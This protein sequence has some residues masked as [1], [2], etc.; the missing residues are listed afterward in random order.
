MMSNNNNNVLYIGVTNNLERRAWE[1]KNDVDDKS[2]TSKYNCKKL[3]YYEVTTDIK[4]AILREK[5][6][7][8]WE[9]EWKNNLINKSNYKWKDLSKEIGIDDDYTNAV[10]EHYKEIAGQ[11]RNDANDTTIGKVENRNKPYPN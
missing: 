11:A 1:H 2:F 7:K 10:K 3:V 8:K 4:S 9:R 5:Q 6:L